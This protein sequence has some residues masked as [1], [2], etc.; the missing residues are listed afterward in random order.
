MR[1]RNQAM[2]YVGYT[3]GSYVIKREIRRRLD[4]ALGTPPSRF[5]RTRDT[6]LPLVGLALA[7]AAVGALTVAARSR[8]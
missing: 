5:K 8:R 7:G 2:G 6:V 4:D 3:V 1:R